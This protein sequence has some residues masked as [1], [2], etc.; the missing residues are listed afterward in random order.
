MEPILTILLQFGSLAG[1]AAAITAIINILKSFNIVQDGTAGSWSAGANL[2]AMVA[3]VALRFFAPQIEVEWLDAQAAMFAQIAL[4]ISGLL[5]Q[6]GVGKWVHEL[7]ASQRLPFIGFSRTMV[8]MD[9][10]EAE[11]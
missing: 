8:E 6:L 9:K 7:F 1:V 4:I 3:L 10:W 2:L 5:F 11:S